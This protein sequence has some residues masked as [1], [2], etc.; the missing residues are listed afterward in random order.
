MSDKTRKNDEIYDGVNVIDA[1]RDVLN[2]CR[3]EESV[4]DAS[5]S[6]VVTKTNTA[7]ELLLDFLNVILKE[8][9]RDAYKKD[10]TA[11]RVFTTEMILYD[12]FLRRL[13]IDKIA[14][15]YTKAADKKVIMDIICECTDIIC[16]NVVDT[17]DKLA[18]WVNT[19]M[20][21]TWQEVTENKTA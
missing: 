5:Y 13:D 16:N 10:K 8:E 12:Y 18:D 20:L 21:H 4:K 6:Y 3:S 17:Y 7:R 9:Y 14:K 2:A 15:K 11:K 1:V 19:Y